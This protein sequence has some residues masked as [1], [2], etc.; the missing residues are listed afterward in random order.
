MSEKDKSGEGFTDG[1]LAPEKLLFL[2]HA[3]FTSFLLYVSQ[4]HDAEESAEFYK[5][6]GIQGKELGYEIIPVAIR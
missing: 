5:G 2:V 3:I 1:T 6:L 4:V